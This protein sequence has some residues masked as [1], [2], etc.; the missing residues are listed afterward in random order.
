M[1]TP[2]RPTRVR[3]AIFDLDGTLAD[4]LTTIGRSV[5]EALESLG[6]PEHPIDAYRY[7]VGDGV[8]V[9][10]QRALPPGRAELLDKLKAAVRRQYDLHPLRD[11][12]L[13]D[14]IEALLA[15]LRTR[16]VS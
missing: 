12:R 13:F 2:E 10:C 15:G 4:T 16:Q 1:T 3:A 11:T 6:L 7:F 14:G 9:L 8:T 5:N